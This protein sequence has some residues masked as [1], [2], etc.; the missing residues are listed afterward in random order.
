M[1]QCGESL[2]EHVLEAG[3]M[4]VADRSAVLHM[5]LGGAVG[6][7][8]Y[9]RRRCRAAAGLIGLGQLGV[10]DELLA[11]RVNQCAAMLLHKLVADGSQPESIEI[12]ALGPAFE[13]NDLKQVAGDAPAK[14][15][16]A[17]EPAQEGVAR[18]VVFEVSTGRMVIEAVADA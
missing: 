9:D 2:H 14:V 11:P 8:L 5:Q 17:Y 18:T 10:A 4:L 1:V 13:R 12:F 16:M 3:E 6:F 7:I 15:L